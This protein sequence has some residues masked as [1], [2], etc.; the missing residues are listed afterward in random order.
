[1]VSVVSVW[2][3]VMVVPGSLLTGSETMGMLKG[4]GATGLSVVGK[5]TSDMVQVL[6]W[7]ILGMLWL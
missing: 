3:D 2:E 5:S 1:L 6:V 7:L 4:Q